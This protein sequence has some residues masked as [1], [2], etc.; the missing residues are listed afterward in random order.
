MWAFLIEI[1]PRIHQGV[2]AFS[3]HDHGE[4][5]APSTPPWPTRRQAPGSD[6]AVGHRPAP[7]EGT[8]SRL[9]DAS[10]A[11]VLDT[12]RARLRD[13][14]AC[15]YLRPWVRRNSSRA[16]AACR[17]ISSSRR[18]G[19]TSAAGRGGGIGFGGGGGGSVGADRPVSLRA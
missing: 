4:T 3:G 12:R 19:T 11:K 9:S 6:A 1:E 16:A 8:T 17:C 5:E 14:Q 18:S 15:N 10:P 13:R 2:K 7:D